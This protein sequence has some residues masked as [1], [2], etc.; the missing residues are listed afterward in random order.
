MKRKSFELSNF[1]ESSIANVGIT[2]P[3]MNEFNKNY[4]NACLLVVYLS[5]LACLPIN[6][7]DHLKFKELTMD[8]TRI[9]SPKEKNEWRRMEE[10]NE[11]Y[12]SI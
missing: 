3:K 12:E 4:E 9:I 5:S 11:N 2:T 7:H 10:Y 1:K 6:F 8:T